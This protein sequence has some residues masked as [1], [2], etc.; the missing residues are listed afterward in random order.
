MILLLILGLALAVAGV[1]LVARAAG[2]V[3]FGVALVAKRIDDYGFTG[4][5]PEALQARPAPQA[6]FESFAERIG[7]FLAQH[8]RS[9]RIS[10]LS[11]R[12]RKRLAT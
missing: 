6:L 1:T 5:T 9:I 10:A 11:S 7:R 4:R 3:R 8:S 12:S 2:S